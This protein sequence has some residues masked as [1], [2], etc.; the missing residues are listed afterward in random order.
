[1]SLTCYEIWLK[2]ITKHRNNSNFSLCRI[3]VWYIFDSIIEILRVPY[4]KCPI[5]ILSLQTFIWQTA[6]GVSLVFEVEVL[7]FRVDQSQRIEMEVSNLRNWKSFNSFR[8][9]KIVST[10]WQTTNWGIEMK[11]KY[12]EFHFLPFSPFSSFVS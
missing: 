6:N 5:G 4:H 7:L 11:L 12:Y 2:S 10:T 3:F 1:M 9:W 8:F